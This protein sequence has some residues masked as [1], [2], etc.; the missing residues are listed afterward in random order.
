MQRHN[1]NPR[2]DW[3]QKVESLGLTFHSGETPYWDES[4]Y[5]SFTM[6]EVLEIE[7]VSQELFRLCC[8][9]VEHIFDAKLWD[10]FQIPQS[11]VP[12]IQRSWKDDDVA[13][14]GRFDLGLDASGV[15]KL[16]EF[17]GDTPTSLFEAAVVQWYWLQELHPD[18]DQFNSIHEHLIETWKISEL[19]SPVHLAC[20][21]G[22]DEEFVTTVY[23]QDTAIQA[24]LKTKRIF[25][26][27]VGWNGREF[28][29]LENKPIR[30]LFK[31]YPWE[32]MLREPF[33]LHLP[34]E[35]CQ[36]IEPPWKML[37]SN[38]QILVLLWEMFPDHP[39]LLP[40]FA[41]SARLGNDWV[42]KPVFGRG[43]ASITSHTLTELVTT[44]GIP[45]VEGGFIYQAYC[46][47]LAHA[48]HYPILGSWIV[49]GESCGI[50]IRES[51]SP[52]TI[53]SSRFV[54]HLIQA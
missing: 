40:A 11:M 26:E 43:G 17:N 21:K 34:K 19:T 46:P 53:E 38:K 24:G 12:L 42:K 33:G 39:N 31:L 22:S 41:S 3:K 47:P 32:W 25:M 13:L 27:D 14:Y 7:R 45:A 44:P 23:L 16:Y 18:C 36:F 5:Y 54:P 1:S 9:A 15:P 50:G 30:S 28:V 20:S 10:Q 2:V 8:L 35:A 6:S 52:V 48:N 4:I 29:D 49:G 37:L 51:D